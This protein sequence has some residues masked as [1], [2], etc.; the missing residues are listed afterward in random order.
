MK[1]GNSFNKDRRNNIPNNLCN[2]YGIRIK[3]K[4]NSLFKGKRTQ[5]GKKPCI[6][7]NDILSNEINRKKKKTRP[8]SENNH[9]INF[10][11]KRNTKNNAYF[12][13]EFNNNPSNPFPF[14]KN[15]SQPKKKNFALKNN[16]KS[17]IKPANKFNIIYGKFSEKKILNRMINNNNFLKKVRNQDEQ[18][19]AINNI[20][21]NNFNN[22][23]NI[24]SNLNGKGKS[25]NSKNG[26]KFFN[27]NID[28]KKGMVM[29]KIDPN[30][31]TIDLNCAN[32]LNNIGATCYMNATIQCLAHV[33]QLTIYLLKHQNINKCMQNHKLA[34]AYTEVLINLWKNK[35]IKNYSPNN[36]KD[37]IS[38]MN[39]LFAG[40]Q[41]NDSKDL[42]IFLM[43][44]LHTELNK[45]ETIE[46]FPNVNQYDYETTFNSFKIYYKNNF[47][48]I[49][50]ELFFGMCN[51][52][53]TC[54]TCSSTTYNIQCFNILIF[55]LEEV[56]KFK[57]RIQ[58]NVDIIECFEY[59]Q[60]IDT[61]S[62][63]NQIYCNK[64]N[65]MSNSLNKTQ[66]IISP[67]VLVIN[68]NRGKGL[69]YDI[70]INFEEY[71]NI[72]QFVYYKQSPSFYELIGIVTH[73]GQSDMSGHFIAFCKSFVDGKWY[74]YNDSLVNITTFEEAK[75]TGMPYILFYSFIQK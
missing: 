21:I 64:C 68:L 56:R 24:N 70:H 17:G 35:S 58:N 52:M 42:I 1:K 28:N 69:Q 74:K 14:I 2:R 65:F 7:I 10:N 73:F 4:N 57:N 33:S 34:N 59:Y 43:E 41:A 54:C 8:N 9:R 25:N 53:M 18:R 39:N 63:Q 49:I 12:L 32:G 20:H 6:N 75:T 11:N 31:Y 30:L 5:S 27:K 51:S 40:I 3:D 36:F 26:N 72:E 45:K 67:N 22:L 50:S 44:T 55:P 15:N 62:G 47:N 46:V 38:Q 61:M 23:Y 60:K 66:I 16:K 48:S 29:L 37:V 13:N 19:R 71:L